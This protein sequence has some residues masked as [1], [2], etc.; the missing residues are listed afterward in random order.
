MA[1]RGRRVKP[2]EKNHALR[3]NK[4]TEGQSKRGRLGKTLSRK[5]WFHRGEEKRRVEK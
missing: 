1:P 3:E 2:G 4:R 5:F